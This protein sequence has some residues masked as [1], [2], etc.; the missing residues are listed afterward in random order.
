MRKCSGMSLT[1]AFA[2]P[3]RNDARRA[4]SDDPAAIFG[5]CPATFAGT[6]SVLGWSRSFSSSLAWRPTH[7]SA[8]AGLWMM[9][10]S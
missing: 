2:S 7:F 10:F 8:P 5:S 4:W 9:A 6:G 1:A 3:F